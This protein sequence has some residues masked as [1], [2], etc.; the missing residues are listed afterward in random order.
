MAEV[1]HNNIIDIDLESGTLFRSFLNHT[2][3]SG[4][5]NANWYGVRVFRKG[6][7]IALS[8]C[9]VQGLFMPASGSAILISDGTH[10][11]VS[12]NEAAVLLPQ[13]C[14]NV[15]G[16]FTLTI[17]IIGTNSYSITDTVRIIDGVVADTYS[18]NPVAPTAAVP[19][20]QEIIALYDDMLDTVEHVDER[21]DDVEYKM[22]NLAEDG[23]YTQGSAT[24][25]LT[26][27]QGAITSAGAITIEAT[28][29]HAWLT[30]AQETYDLQLDTSSY[31]YNICY[32]RNGSVVKYTSWQSTSP[33]QFDDT[34]HDQIG[35]TVKGNGN[36]NIRDLLGAIVYYTV[37]EGNIG[38]LATKD[39]AVAKDQGTQNAGKAMVVGQDGNV[40]PGNVQVDSALETQGV[41]ADAKS[42]GDSF[43]ELGETGSIIKV[44][45]D[46]YYQLSRGMVNGGT[47]PVEEQIEPNNMTGY[48]SIPKAEIPSGIFFNP[49]FYKVNTMFIKN[50]Y[51]I[52]GTYTTWQT[53]S[54]AQYSEPGDYDAL[55]LNVRKLVGTFSDEELGQALFKKDIDVIGDLVT[56][57]YMEEYV[58]SK[59]PEINVKGAKCI[60]PDGFSSRIM[61]DIMYNGRYFTN[62]DPDDYKIDSVGETWVATNGD[63][64]N[65]DGTEGNP[66]QT[67]TKALTQLAKT[68]KLKAGTYNQGT[69]YATDADFSG[70]NLIGV[71]GYATLHNNSAGNYAKT[72]GSAYF[73]NIRFEHGNSNTNSAFSATCNSSGNTVLFKNCIF[74]EGGANGL[75]ATGIDVICIGCTAYGNKLDGFNY[76]DKTVGG[77]TYIPNVLEIDCVGYNNGNAESGSDSCNGSTAHDGTKIIRL[78]GEYYSCYGGV[79]AEIARTG[80]EPTISVNYGVLAHDSTGVSNYKASFWASVNTKMY[81]YDCLSYGGDYDI[82]AIN[83][84]KVVSRRLTTGRDEPSISK[85]TTATVIQH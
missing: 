65:G 26:L 71:G 38:N 47:N 32:M 56:K 4:D 43:K 76:H 77:V 39:Y 9:S 34:V 1:Y 22:R 28:R 73:E 64:T 55:M 6:E 85:E 24:R 14:Y 20:Y 41:P 15:K 53:T 33:I 42:V 17:K 16:Q 54:P 60:Y 78:N 2:I 31:S 84:A 25:Y 69:H 30:Q 7:P 50:G 74:R 67:I 8:G 72:T 23:Y 81:L 63:D 12:G 36:E 10:T 35:I 79:I 49:N 52:Q 13:A 37:Q 83:D 5:N 27:E 82:T 21:I 75:S 68:I 57:N 19:T 45:P 80:E 48:V 29:G 11:W 40:A 51:I 46:V 58:D 62:I 70:H 3:G 61:P 18:E 59:I 66:F 44:H